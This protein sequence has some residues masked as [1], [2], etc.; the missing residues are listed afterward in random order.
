MEP[1]IHRLY[2]KKNY[3]KP[4]LHRLNKNKKNYINH[5]QRN[6]IFKTII[7]ICESVACITSLCV[8]L[9]WKVTR[10]YT[11]ESQRFA[12]GE[13][14]REKGVVL[15]VTLWHLYVSLCDFVWNNLSFDKFILCMIFFR[16]EIV[17]KLTWH[18]RFMVVILYLEI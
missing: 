8:I 6:F 7:L 5:N 16:L 13:K 17:I 18:S 10:R 3:F 2:K 12:E 11:E 9:L 1:L 14:E 4:Q 15:C